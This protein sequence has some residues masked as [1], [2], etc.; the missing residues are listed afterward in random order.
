MKLLKKC[1][2][3]LTLLYA[4]TSFAADVAKY[5]I[6]SAHSSVSF[7]VAHLVVSSVTGKFKEFSGTFEFDPSDFTKTKLEATAET[8]SVDTGTPKRDDHLRS[9]DFFDAKKYK[10]MTFTSTSAE[11]TGAK[12]FQ[13]H[14]KMTLRGVTKDAT[15]DVAYRGEVKT[16]DRT[17]QVF[18]ATTKINR[19]DF[20]IKFQ[21]F[22]EKTP[23]VGDDVTIE[24]LCEGVSS[25]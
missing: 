1:V 13:L 6:D 21:N 2:A 11:K 8:A 23:A 15:F 16:A 4:S 14:G 22:I 20:G 24:I 19:K 10:T 12:T 25:N 17:V 5:K 7:E 18:K 9:A 3:T